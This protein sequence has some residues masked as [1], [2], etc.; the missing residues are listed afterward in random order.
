MVRKRSILI[1]L[2]L[3]LLLIYAQQGSAAGAESERTKVEKTG[4]ETK[5]EGTEEPAEPGES[6]ETKEPTEPEERT[7]P[8]E[9]EGPEEPEEPEVP[10][11]KFQVEIPGEDGKN[12]YYVTSPQARIVHTSKRGTTKYQLTC[13]GQTIAEGSLSETG[14]AADVKEFREGKN[15][16]H[17]WMEDEGGKLVEGMELRKVFQIDT[18]PPKLQMSVPRG[19]DAWYQGEV[20]LQVTAGDTGSGTEEIVCVTEGGETLRTEKGEGTFVIKKTSL[21]G[22]GT[23]VI[24]KATD[25]AGNESR[26]TARLYIDGKAPQVSIK[27]AKDYLITSKPVT[28]TCQVEEENKLNHVEADIS[29]EDVT[30]TKK[31]IQVSDWASQGTGQKAEQKLAED[32]IYRVQVQAEDA[33]GH[34]GE[35]DLQVIIDKENP[36]IRHVEELQGRYLREFSW[37]YEKE[38]VIQ[39]FTTYDYEIRLDGKPFQTGKSIR[40]EGRHMLEVEAEDAAGN[41]ARAR[42][43]FILDHTAPEIQFLDTKDG[44]KYEEQ[45]TVCIKT[46]NSNDWINEIRINGEVQDITKGRDVYEYTLEEYGNYE[47]QASAKDHAGNKSEEKIVVQV[48]R[49][50]GVLQKLAKPILRT[51][52]VESEQTV[53]GKEQTEKI[54]EKK[55]TGSAIAGICLLATAG[56]GGTFWILRRKIRGV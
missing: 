17:I 21:Q 36:V 54:D 31:T 30:G 2:C 4:E 39:D 46:E 43:E 49:K 25:R 29:W 42:A 37:D 35:T 22:Q 41:Q 55:P 15:R 9:P 14:K 53:E 20:S 44:Q 27:G 26:K 50:E 16:L 24:V 52:G 56:G 1:V 18:Q 34:V 45:K 32:G 28:L 3:T 11:T 40:E 23:G 5:D 7:E 48:V 6:T 13:E 12:G 10:I 19:F 8:E 47:I 33:A 51:L 38:E